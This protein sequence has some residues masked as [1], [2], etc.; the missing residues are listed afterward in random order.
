MNRIFAIGDLHLSF[1]SE[2]PMGIFGANW[3]DHHEKIEANWRRSVTDGDIVLL[4]GDLSWALKYED[5]KADLD[6]ISSLPGRKV[7]MKGNHDLWWQS[8][9]RLRSDYKDMLFLQNDSIVVNFCEDGSALCEG[10]GLAREGEKEPSADG[11]GGSAGVALCGSRGWLTPQ[12]Q[13]FSEAADRKIY[14]RELIR[15]RL[16]LDDAK[17]KGARHIIAC[18]HFAPSAK[19]D[20]R[21]GFMDLFDEYGVDQVVYGHLHGR[22]AYKKGVK[23][24]NNGVEYLLASA[25][26]VGFDP[27]CIYPRQ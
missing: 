22:E 3:D 4:L 15:L 7:L 14:E 9:T 21:S 25:D 8:I 18:L 23:G 24:Y 26:F 19:Q 20:M 17:R 1:T 2:K 6:W 11:T 12:E 27:L 13:S 16:S 10:A 5:A